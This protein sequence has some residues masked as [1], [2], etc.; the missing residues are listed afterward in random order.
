MKPHKS[1]TV[2]RQTARLRSEKISRHISAHKR[3]IILL[4]RLIKRSISTPFRLITF[5]GKCQAS[6]K[7]NSS[8]SYTARKETASHLKVSYMSNF[9][10]SC[11]APFLFSNRLRWSEGRVSWASRIVVADYRVESFAQCSLVREDLSWPE[12]SA[13]TNCS[14]DDGWAGRRWL[15]GYLLAL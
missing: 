5:H 14:P 10:F 3:I 1:G 2:P 13:P 4:L 12:T 11:C 15:I 6:S 7:L 9:D 8:N